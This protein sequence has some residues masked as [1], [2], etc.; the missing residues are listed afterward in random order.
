MANITIIGTIERM[1]YLPN[2]VIVT[3]N[4]YKRG[5]KEKKSGK[6]VDDR[7]YTWKTIWKPY[8]K[9]FFNTQFND[10]MVVEVKGDV[11]PYAIEHNEIVDG[12]SIIGQ[13]MNLFS[14][15]KLGLKQ[16]KKMMK[17][18]QLTNTEV[19]DLDEYNTPDF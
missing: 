6:V 15:P 9:N 8:F 16:E 3:I 18:S 7:I 10:G 19:P 5:Y 11:I 14:M 4:E 12:Y 1:H 17:E 2:S 13:T